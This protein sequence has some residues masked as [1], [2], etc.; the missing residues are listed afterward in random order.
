[1]TLDKQQIE[2]LIRL[3]SASTTS[4]VYN[5]SRSEYDDLSD[6]LKTQLVKLTS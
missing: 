6:Q 2:A 3:I 1:M 5:S 4:H